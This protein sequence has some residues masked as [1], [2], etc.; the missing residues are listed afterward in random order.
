MFRP[1]SAIL[2]KHIIKE[3]TA[4]C[5]SSIIFLKYMVVVVVVVVVVVILVL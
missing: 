3:V 1:H 2:R 4:V 5:T